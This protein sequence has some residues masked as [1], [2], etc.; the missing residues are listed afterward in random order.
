MYDLTGMNLVR[1]EENQEG[2]YLV[3]LADESWARIWS[4]VYTDN[5]DIFTVEVHAETGEIEN[6]WHDSPAFGNG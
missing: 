3:Q 6:I 4:I 5:V 2:L 1:G